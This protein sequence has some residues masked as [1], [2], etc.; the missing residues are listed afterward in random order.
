MRGNFAACIAVLLTAVLLVSGC[1]TITR[2]GAP[3]ESF[4]IED[5]IKALEAAFGPA[6]SIA[7]YYKAKDRKEARNE[8]IDGRLALYNIRYIQFIRNLGAD[9]QQLDAATDIMILGLSIAGTLVGSSQAKT[10]LAAAAALL[11]GSKTAIDKH[12]YFEKTVPALVSTMNA[13]RKTVFLKILA[14]RAQTIDL[15]PLAQAISDLYEYEL[16]GTLLGAVEAIQADA[17]AK[18]AVADSKIRVLR[19][20]TKSDID[21]MEKINR[22]AA[23]L[24]K[25]PKKDLKEVNRV[26]KEVEAEKSDYT[27]FDSAAKA[28]DD[29]VR[30]VDDLDKWKKALK[31]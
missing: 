1:S 7:G 18:N 15:Y 30:D 25:D 4:K 13:Q 5:D 28:L 8:F 2:G 9:K 3:A 19:A 6:A 17:G 11:T 27:D 10:N 22:T 16:A 20:R 23:A 21:A 26:L 24:I 12:F 29:A 31:I 14:G